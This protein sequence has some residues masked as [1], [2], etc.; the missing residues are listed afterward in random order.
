MVAPCQDHHYICHNC[1]QPLQVVWVSHQSTVPIMGDHLL[2]M[3]TR[4]FI[5]RHNPLLLAM[6]LEIH[7][8]LEA[9]LLVTAHHGVRI[10][11]LSFFLCST[12]LG[13]FFPL[14]SF[15]PLHNGNNS[16]IC[17]SHFLYTYIFIVLLFS[18]A[19]NKSTH[20]H[21]TAISKR[22][23]R[24]W[25]DI[26]ISAASASALSL[27]CQ[28]RARKAPFLFPSILSLCC[29]IS[30]ISNML[31]HCCLWL[32]HVSFIWIFEVNL[33]VC[34]NGVPFYGCL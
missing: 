6:I 2:L 20:Q 28:E 14:F 29:R 13:F 19:Q 17:A 7:I 30:P 31:I 34:F 26:M 23:K 3:V 9:A 5:W 18:S 22:K 11:F 1:L 16:F 4:E 8:L 12:I 25:K 21:S 32:L 10:L 24:L 15:F 33:L 27:L